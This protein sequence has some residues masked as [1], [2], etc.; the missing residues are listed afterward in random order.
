MFSSWP[1]T[2]RAIQFGHNKEVRLEKMQVMSWLI[3]G[4]VVV[5][6]D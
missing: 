5:D 4:D 3:F 6:V 1:S 2:K